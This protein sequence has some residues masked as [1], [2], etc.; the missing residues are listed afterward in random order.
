MF[1]VAFVTRT[2]IYFAAY[3]GP[4]RSCS[5]GSALTTNVRT[6]AMAQTTVPLNT[7]TEQPTRRAMIG[8]LAAAGAIGATPALASTLA[9]ILD[10]IGGRA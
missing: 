2:C 7:P 5:F 1:Y 9:A 6:H 8:R 3:S 4:I 10:T